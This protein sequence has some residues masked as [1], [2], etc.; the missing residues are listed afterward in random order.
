MSSI[1]LI[2][3]VFIRAQPNPSHSLPFEMRNYF[4]ND[5]NPGY[6]CYERVSLQNK[7][8]YFCDKLF[9]WITTCALFR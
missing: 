7:F 8:N 6:A 2:Q 1:S 9:I 4:T 3:T 5:G